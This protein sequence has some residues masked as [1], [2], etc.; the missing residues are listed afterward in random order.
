[1][2]PPPD[3]QAGAFDPLTPWAAHLQRLFRQDALTATSLAEQVLDQI[4]Q[5]NIKGKNLRAIITVAPRD[6]VLNRA[7]QLDQETK[8]GCIRGSL[9]GTSL[10]VKVSSAIAAPE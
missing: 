1:M 3:A 5:H 10:I 4:D 6:Q 8:D 9:R 2:A 7:R